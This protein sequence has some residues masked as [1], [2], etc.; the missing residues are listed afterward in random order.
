MGGSFVHDEYYLHLFGVN[1]PS[2]DNIFE[3]WRT[4][5]YMLHSDKTRG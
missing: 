2:L 4:S 3:N 5:L 1:I